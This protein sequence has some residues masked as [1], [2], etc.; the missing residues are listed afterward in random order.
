MLCL[1]ISLNLLFSIAKN[2][3]AKDMVM[4]RIEDSNPDVQRQALSCMSKIM[5]NHWEFLR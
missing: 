5:V 4:A 2:L 3:G 1:T